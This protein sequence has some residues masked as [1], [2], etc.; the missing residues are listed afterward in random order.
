MATAPCGSTWGCV[1][2]LNCARRSNSTT[3][4]WS[5]W[6]NVSIFCWVS[7]TRFTTT[8]ASASSGTTANTSSAARAAEFNR[9]M[10]QSA[11]T[12]KNNLCR[13]MAFASK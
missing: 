3:G 10:P 5:C 2:T 7:P 11:T 13:F 8:T 4:T 6:P 12:A 1:W 9:V